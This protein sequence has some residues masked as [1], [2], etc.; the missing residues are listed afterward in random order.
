MHAAHERLVY[1]D[2]KAAQ[3]QGPVP[4]QAL[5]V[6][7]VV[8]LPEDQVQ[9]LSKAADGLAELGLIVEAFGDDAALIREVPA[10]LATKADWAQMIRDL[11]EILGSET[12]QDSSPL[13]RRME[14]ALATLACYTSVRSGR[15]LTLPEM[16]ALLRKM[17]AT[18]A[19]AQCNHGRPTSISLSLGDL[20][21]LFQRA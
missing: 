14:E 10:L 5:L 6:P 20:E 7:E 13:A 3:T 8:N 16:D 9:I 19:S 2:L 17:E 21:K 15:A 11:V 4:R 1:E 12:D 18:P